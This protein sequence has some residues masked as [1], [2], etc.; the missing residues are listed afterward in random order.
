MIDGSLCPNV[1]CGHSCNVCSAIA[2]TYDIDCFEWCAR[3]RTPLPGWESV[4]VGAGAV[5]EG[6]GDSEKNEMDCGVVADVRRCTC[7]TIVGIR[8][9]NMQ[10]VDEEVSAFAR[11]FQNHLVDNVTKVERSV[12]V[13]STKVFVAALDPS[14]LE[15]DESILSFGSGMKD[16]VSIDVPSS[17]FFALT[18]PVFISLATF[19]ATDWRSKTYKSQGMN[20]IVPASVSAITIKP[21]SSATNEGEWNELAEPITIAFPV[22]VAN[23]LCAFWDHSTGAWST[24]GV[25][26]VPSGLQT[27]VLCAV[28]HL[29]IFAIFEQSAQR[30]RCNNLGVL[31]P[32]KLAA[33]NKTNFFGSRPV[34]FV[35]CLAALHLSLLAYSIHSCW[36]DPSDMIATLVVVVDGDDSSRVVRSPNCC[37]KMD[38][39]FHQG[40]MYAK[41]MR[42]TFATLRARKYPFMYLLWRLFVSCV[43]DVIRLHIAADL[44]LLPFDVKQIEREMKHNASESQ[45]IVKPEPLPPAERGSN[46][47]ELDSASTSVTAVSVAIESTNAVNEQVATEGNPR[48]ACCELADEMHEVLSLKRLETR[49]RMSW[50]SQRDELFQISCFSTFKMAFC[51]L[52][53]LLSFRG[54][55]LFEA[56]HIRAIKLTNKVFASYFL[57]ALFFVR[58]AVPVNADPACISRGGAEEIVR[59]FIVGAASSGISFLILFPLKFQARRGI[60]VVFSMKDQQHV[61]RMTQMKEWT[62]FLG[63]CLVFLFSVFFILAF[64]ANVSR[65]DGDKWFLSALMSFLSQ[66]FIVPVVLSLISA[67][68]VQ[69]I[70][71]L[72]D[73]KENIP[74]HAP[75]VK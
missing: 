1:T 70:K 4:C 24:A 8:G 7:E 73:A 60:K 61:L 67:M 46:L 45:A 35:C 74:E 27:V 38:D 36:K 25:V 68:V 58:D 55:S 40:L 42:S 62:I 30:L 53:P 20:R 47:L 21:L 43:V 54:S 6:N 31:S 71:A 57:S 64:L 39:G 41:T 22:Q 48:Q 50:E 9:L 10:K 23:P 72:P 69:L 34:I 63:E 28:S 2:Q 14:S 12:A 75:G 56:P 16:G 33:I 18:E 13:G 15:E 32:A 11:M 3:Q 37:S 17:M 26:V 65:A 44:N 51:M 29:S 49:F 59:S 52:Q 5:C 66:F 19:N